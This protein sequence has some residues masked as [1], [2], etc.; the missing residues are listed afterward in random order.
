MVADILLFLFF[1]SLKSDEE[2]DSAKEPQ[3]DFSEVQGKAWPCVGPSVLTGT[4]GEGPQRDGSRGEAPLKRW[5]LCRQKREVL[6][7]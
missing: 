4:L 7:Q 5:R 1:Q 3:N 6:G 2:A